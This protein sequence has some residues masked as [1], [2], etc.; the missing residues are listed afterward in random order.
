MVVVDGIIPSMIST[1]TKLFDQ[2]ITKSRYLPT[3]PSCLPELIMG[4]MMKNRYDERRLRIKKLLKPVNITHEYRDDEQM[5]SVHIHGVRLEP[6]AAIGHLC[7]TINRAKPITVESYKNILKYNRLSCDSCS[8]HLRDGVYPMDIK[9]LP[10]LSRNRYKSDFL[11]LRSMLEH[12][13]ELP[14]FSSWTEFN[15]FMLCPSFINSIQ[16]K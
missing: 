10:F 13:E 15:I 11:Y 12:D 3:V 6:S 14:W 7:E 5:S 16:Y 2:P 9:C 4:F 1:I 8:Q